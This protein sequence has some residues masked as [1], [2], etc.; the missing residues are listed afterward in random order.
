MPRIR[1]P[2]PLVGLIQFCAVVAFLGGL[3][4]ILVGCGASTKTDAPEPTP[5]NIVNG[6]NTQVI[7]MP[8]GFRNIAFTCYG[9]NGVYVTSRG[10]YQTGAENA[11]PLASSVFVLADDP[12]CKGGPR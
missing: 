7:R 4:W 1:T 10:T 9:S 8:D 3:A 6:T 5:D 11:T 2:R 12:H